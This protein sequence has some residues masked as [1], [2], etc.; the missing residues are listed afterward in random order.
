MPGIPEHHNQKFKQKK[1]VFVNRKRITGFSQKSAIH[2]DNYFI[3]N[4][5]LRYSELPGISG[6]CI[7]IVSKYELS[8]PMNI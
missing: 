8:T 2:E 4:Y 1:V 6:T 5:R 3:L 7:G